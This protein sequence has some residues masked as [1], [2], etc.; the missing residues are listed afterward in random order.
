MAVDSC[1][2]CTHSAVGSHPAGCGNPGLGSMTWSSACASREVGCVFVRVD[3]MPQW[4]LLFLAEPRYI[5]LRPRGKLVELGVIV[6][7]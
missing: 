5:L 7:A 3:T 4:T 1:C 2:C 6:K